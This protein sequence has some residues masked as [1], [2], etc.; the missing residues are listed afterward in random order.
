MSGQLINMNSLFK[1]RSDRGTWLTFIGYA[2]LAFGAALTFA[3][4][5]VDRVVGMGGRATLLRT[6]GIRDLIIGRG[7][8]SDRPELWLLPRA[9]S[10]SMDTAM[11]LHGI[12]TRKFDL[13]RGTLGTAIAVTFLIAEVVLINR[14]PRSED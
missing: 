1:Q 5:W 6:I 8:L 10:D 11:M 2:C 13:L 3:P 4:R 14:R 12:R 9:I 7:L